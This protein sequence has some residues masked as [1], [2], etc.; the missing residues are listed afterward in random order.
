MNNLEEH[1]TNITPKYK[2]LCVYNLTDGD[3]Y[4]KDL[5][6]DKY[7]IVYFG[8][9]INDDR[10]IKIGGIENYVNKLKTATH[11][12]SYKPKKHYGI[13]GGIFQNIYKLNELEPKIITGYDDY[14]KNIII[15]KAKIDTKFSKYFNNNYKWILNPDNY[16]FLWSASLTKEIK[17]PFKGSKLP[18]RTRFGFVNSDH[19]LYNLI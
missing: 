8:I 14:E 13:N 4:N 5:L 16:C 11:I 1:L 2:N 12:I 9:N 17:I 15:K 3:G 6:L 10:I 7:G 18:N 19:E